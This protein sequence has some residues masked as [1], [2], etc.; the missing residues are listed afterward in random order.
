VYKKAQTRFLVLVIASTF[1]VG[2]C[3]LF[4]DDPVA[5]PPATPTPAPDA[6]A[7]KP[8]SPVAAVPTPAVET[9]RKEYPQGRR[10]PFVFSPP[11]PASADT[12]EDRELGPLEHFK[13]D[14]LQLVAIVTGTAV[15]KAMF[16]DGTGFGHVAKEGDRIG[17]DGGRITAIRGNE[18]EITVTASP[19]SASDADPEQGTPDGLREETESAPIVIRLSDTELQLEKESASNESLLDDLDL[20]DKKK[21]G[22]GA[23]GQ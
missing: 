6:A 21:A 7:A 18:V 10:D 23:R 19:A 17:T 13:L 12:Q 9:K 5:P 1:A 11:P 2:G 4:E 8:A 20:D 16:I 15:P 22:N 14:T 3:D